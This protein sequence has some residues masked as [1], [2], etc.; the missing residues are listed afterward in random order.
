MAALSDVSQSSLKRLDEALVL[1]GKAKVEEHESLEL[2][3]IPD[4]RVHS[5]FSTVLALEIWLEEIVKFCTN[6]K[7]FGISCIDQ[8]S[9]Y[10]LRTLVTMLP[11]TEI[12]N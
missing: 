1:L 2:K 4:F 3:F 6:P 5:N 10:L 8:L 12:Y 9:I 11:P 7:E